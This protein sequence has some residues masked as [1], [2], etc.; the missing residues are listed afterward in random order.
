MGGGPGNSF[1]KG[2]T[3]VQLCEM[4]PDDAAAEAW[5]IEQRWP[6]GIR[7]PLAATTG[8]ALPPLP[9]VLAGLFSSSHRQSPCCATHNSAAAAPVVVY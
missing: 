6:D 4:F 7:C 9:G 5:F 1:R 3:L 2:I 8:A